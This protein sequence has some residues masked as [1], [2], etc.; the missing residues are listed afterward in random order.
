MHYKDFGYDEY[1]QYLVGPEWRGLNQ[2]FYENRDKY[3]CGVCG[4]RS[5]LVLHKRSYKF[6]SLGELK[7]KYRGDKTKVMRYLHT[8]M[9][10]LCRHCHRQVH[11]LPNGDRVP[12]Q[13]RALKDRELRLQRAAR[14]RGTTSPKTAARSTKSRGSF[15]GSYFKNLLKK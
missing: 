15:L 10:Y 14:K 2:Y 3:E 4:E 9:V 8:Y 1:D 13:Y 7:R 11:F 12:M 5:G 6:L